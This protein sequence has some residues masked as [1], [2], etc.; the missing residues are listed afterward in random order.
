[1]F[2]A[3]SAA[4]SAAY[5]IVAGLLISMVVDIAKVAIQNREYHGTDHLLLFAMMLT[6]GGMFFLKLAISI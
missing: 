4:L 3:T 5:A 6:L 2:N 1:M